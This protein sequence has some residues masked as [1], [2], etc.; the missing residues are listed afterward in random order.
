MR[1]IRI[2]CGQ[3]TWQGQPEEEAL[4]DIAAAGYEGAPAGLRRDRTAPETQALYDRFGLAPAPGYLGADFWDPAQEAEIFDRARRYAELMAALGCTEL[5][6]AAGGFEWR[7]PTGQTRRQVAGHVSPEDALSDEQFRQFAATLS[8]VGA[9]TLAEGV[10]SCFHN[11]VGSVIETRAEIDRLFGLVDRSVVFMGPDTGHLEWAGADVLAFFRDYADSILTVHL[12]DIDPAVAA[13]GRAA[14]WD[15]RT[16][17]ANGVFQELGQGG[18]DFPA[19]FDALAAADF[20]GWL[21]V[22]TDVTQL[23]SPRHSAEVSR[24]YLRRL[25]F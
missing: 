21:I 12:K 23:P 10:R 25:G 17:T 5:Y 1:N 14:G 3:I 16:F 4:A 8:R 15:Y 9:I 20:S 24:A 22:E 18:I 6:V 2:G 7:T 13:K 19:L 11:H